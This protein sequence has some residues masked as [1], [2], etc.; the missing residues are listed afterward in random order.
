MSDFF[1][2]TAL[3]YIFTHICKCLTV[4]T[5]GSVASSTTGS[6]SGGVNTPESVSSGEPLSLLFLVQAIATTAKL[7]SMPEEY[8][9]GFADSFAF[10][11]LQISAPWVEAGVD[12]TDDNE[13]LT[14]AAT[15]ILEGNLFWAF[16]SLS[17]LTIVHFFALKVASR[18][19]VKATPVMELPHLEMKVAL[20]LV[21]G[22]MDSSFGV[23]VD[24]RTNAG[25]KF[26]ASTVILACLLFAA[27]IL[28]EARDF[29]ATQATW[30]NLGDNFLKVKTSQND[31]VPLEMV[32]P[33]DRLQALVFASPKN[34][35][36]GAWNPCDETKP[37]KT[38]VFGFER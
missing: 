13:S 25:W 14:S 8:R 36:V 28:R 37:L 1:L 15:H 10:F 6:G 38:Q 33:F 29:K 18:F 16:I 11:N 32:S 26:L 22:F 7:S 31:E 30:S 27:W 23:L 2:S 20:A 35:P 34:K 5:S 12:E 4:R 19:E 3:G 17:S 21:M 24:S 9:K